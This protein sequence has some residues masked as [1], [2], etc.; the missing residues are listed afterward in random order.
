MELMRSA[1][2]DAPTFRRVSL[3]L[4]ASQREAKAGANPA[5]RRLSTSSSIST[6]SSSVSQ[7]GSPTFTSALP[8]L[9]SSLPNTHGLWPERMGSLFRA[10][11][12]QQGGPAAPPLMHQAPAE[13]SKVPSLIRSLSKGMDSFR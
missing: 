3:D 12:L 4:S 5:L 8:V 10:S 7:A 9:S 1:Q 11:S 2:Q 6:T 13:T